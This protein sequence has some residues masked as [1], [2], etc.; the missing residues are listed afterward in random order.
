MCSFF[1][2]KITI[3]SSML[4][5]HIRCVYKLSILSYQVS[6]FCFLF[7]FIYNVILNFVLCYIQFWMNFICT[8]THIMDLQD[9]FYVILLL[10]LI[11][12]FVVFIFCY[13]YV[14]FDKIQ[15]HN[16]DNSAELIVWL[17]WHLHLLQFPLSFLSL[18]L[19]LLPFYYSM[20]YVYKVPEM[21]YYS[22]R[23]VSDLIFF[24]F[25]KPGVFPF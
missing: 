5:M 12:L 13:F 7:R 10:I 14:H 23:K 3:L 16:R 8:F 9:I 2:F 20:D 17:A 21:I 25:R 4:T 18:S 11:N 15:V 22:V 19:S 6:L 1:I 24:L